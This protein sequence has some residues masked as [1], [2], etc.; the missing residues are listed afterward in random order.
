VKVRANDRLINE[1]VWPTYLET[2]AILQ[3]HLAQVTDRVIRE[4]LHQNPAEGEV[5]EVA[6]ELEE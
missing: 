1:T 4:V 5:D 6:G 3:E 2:S